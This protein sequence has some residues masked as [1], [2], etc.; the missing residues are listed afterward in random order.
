MKRAATTVLLTATLLAVAFI[1]G[2][3]APASAQRQVIFSEDFEDSPGDF[4]H[5]G[6]GDTWQWGTPLTVPPGPPP[7]GQNLWGTNL[8]GPYPQGCIQSLLSPAIE[9]EGRI[10]LTLTVMLY[11]DLSPGDL[12]TISFTPDGVNWTVL[13]RIQD[14]W[15]GEETWGA[16]EV[17]LPDG[18]YSTIRLNFTLEDL[19]SPGEG[20]GAY[21]DWLRLEGEAIPVPSPEIIFVHYTPLLSPGDLLS[22]E[23][24]VGLPGAPLPLPYTLHLTL[25]DHLD[26]VLEH[27]EIG[28]NLSGVDVLT[29]V[30]T[31]PS[32]GGTYSLKLEMASYGGGRARWN[33]HLSV[34]ERLL[35]EGFGGEPAEGVYLGGGWR[36]GPGEEY[37][38]VRGAALCS[39]EGGVGVENLTVRAS[40]PAS[41]R[42]TLGII[43]SYSLPAGSLGVVTAGGTLLEPRG[44]Y[45]AILLNP[46]TG[47]SGE[48]Y[49]GE[50]GL[51]TDLFDLTALSGRAVNITLSLVHNDSCGSYLWS[52]DCIFISSVGGEG[53]E[54]EMYVRSLS[55]RWLSRGVL[56]LSWNRTNTRDFS[57]YLLFLDNSSFTDLEGREPYLRIADVERTTVT[58]EG[59][60]PGETYYVAVVVEDSRG[61]YPKRAVPLQ[62]RPYREEVNSP[63]V[64]IVSY[65]ESVEVGSRI[66]FDASSS[67]DPDGDPLTFTWNFG[68]NTT[69]EGEKVSHIYRK[70]GLYTV[71]LR[72]SDG[73]GGV[74]ERRLE[75]RV[76]SGNSPVF[77][78]FIE[79]L[80]RYIPTLLLFIALIALL[81]LY[82]LLRRRWRVRRALRTERDVVVGE[83]KKPSVKKREGGPVVRPREGKVDLVPLLAPPRKEEADEEEPREEEEEEGEEG[84]E[85]ERVKVRLRCPNCGADFKIEVERSLAIEGGE[86][87]LVCPHCGKGGVMRW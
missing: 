69:G 26:R 86:K 60:S 36:T 46:L 81:L 50:E 14:G 64:V 17:P 43:H 66:Y 35:L 15:E 53:S 54:E 3:P 47:E 25:T 21:I 31:A 80:K 85:E 51:R 61:M 52:V 22:V 30:L 13:E 2:G 41:T 11:L 78:S 23:V 55:Y 6:R 42:V 77:G 59:L 32:A 8:S 9:V 74:E 48:G 71:V 28:G 7:G 82:L 1:Q 45:P 75:V 70:E 83:V 38:Y 63:P 58:V 68:D 29:A 76:T 20:L 79:N 4:T 72:V 67:Y 40:L 39:G 57:A 84:E 87:Y 10:N 33:G 56:E 34:G 5:T 12:F 49:G 19:T 37:I 24:K 65:P 27:R 16:V 73:R 44:G 62:V 18:L